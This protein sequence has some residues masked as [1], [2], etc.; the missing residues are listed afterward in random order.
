MSEND[1]KDRARRAWGSTPT[2]SANF[3][4]LKPGSK[5]FFE[6]SLAF[7][8]QIEQPWLPEL[9]PFHAM[10][11]LKVLEIGFGPGFDALSFMSHGAIYSGIDITPENVKRTRSHLGYY[12]YSPDV[13]EADA[14]KLPFPAGSFDVVY[15]N[16][17]LHHTPHIELAFAEAARVLRPGGDFYVVLYHRNSIFARVSSVL[18]AAIKRIPIRDRFR[19]LEYNEAG[20]SPLVNIYSRKEVCNMLMRAGFDIKAIDVRKLLPEDMPLFRPPLS[21]IYRSI[22]Q[23]VYDLFGKRFGWYIVAHGSLGASAKSAA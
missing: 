13:R 14:E 22:P 16:G 9:V 4:G 1:A 6:R 11:G 3:E 10:G 19:N 21:L 23:W 15:S 12:G 8:S 7:R 18:I 5:E 17:V 2:G 20:E